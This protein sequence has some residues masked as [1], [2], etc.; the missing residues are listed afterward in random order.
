MN[1]YQEWLA[2][3]ARIA[4]LLNASSVFY[5]AIGHSSSD[6]LSTRKN[7]LLP[8]VAKI[9]KLLAVFFE[10][11]NK[12]L[13]EKASECLASLLQV[14]ADLKLSKPISFDN[15]IPGILQL[16]LTSLAAF[17]SEFSYLIADTENLAFRI[18]E[19]A[20]T[21]LQRSIAVDDEIRDKWKKAFE[22]REEHCERLGALH[23]L[24]HG[25]WAFKINA[26]KG[27]TDLI[28]NEPLLD[29]SMVE[30][31]STT[32]VLTEW[33][34]CREGDNLERK[35]NEAYE[36]ARIYEAGVL[37]GI[38][39][40]KYRYLVMVSKK[41]VRMQPDRKEG[42]MTYRLINIAID[43]DRPSDEAKRLTSLKE[44]EK[45]S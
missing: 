39:L 7:I 19:R 38:E 11:Y 21:H 4:G 33:K 13:P 37:G 34:L 36:Q 29:T 3:S 31:T 25:V 26:E 14:L 35:I 5:T 23:L 22:K 9:E 32:L 44:A 1:W 17:Q 43:P 27:R 41:S 12:I 8:Q 10:N 42:L 28:L 18:T 24:Y 30:R 16:A 20:F 6:N 2:I 15:Q 40:T 45:R